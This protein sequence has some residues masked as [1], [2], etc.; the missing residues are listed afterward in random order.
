MQTTK[1]LSKHFVLNQHLVLTAS[2]L[3]FF[4][5]PIYYIIWTYCLPQAYDNLFLRLSS[6][7]L[8]LAFIVQKYWPKSMQLYAQ[9]LWIFLIVYVAPFVHFFLALKNEFSPVWLACVVVIPFLVSYCIRTINCFII[10]L[11]I[12]ILSAI[13]L[14]WITDGLPLF[15]GQ[16]LEVIPLAVFVVAAAAALSYSNQ[17]LFRKEGQIISMTKSLSG[18]IAH[19]MRN[20]LNNIAITANCLEQHVQHQHYNDIVLS[21]NITTVKEAVYEATQVINLLLNNISKQYIDTN[22]F[23][24]LS[25]AKVIRQAL[26]MYPFIAHQEKKITLEVQQDFNL[27]GKETLINYTL[28][29][30]LKNALYYFPQNPDAEINILITANEKEHSIY[31]RDNT[32]GIS[33]EKIN[34]LFNDFMTSKKNCGTGLGLSFCKRAMQ[35]MQG[36]ISCKSELGKYTEFKLSFPVATFIDAPIP[37]KHVKQKIIQS[38]VDHSKFKGQT[39][40]FIEDN[41]IA[42]KQLAQLLANIDLDV[43]FACNHFEGMKKIQQLNPEVIV[44]DLNMPGLSGL[45]LL[46]TIK[47]A[48]LSSSVVISLSGNVP[49]VQM[50]QLLDDVIVKPIQDGILLFKLQ[51]YLS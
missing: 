11:S 46:H 45:E 31:F 14:Y 7:C 37:K 15:V 24:M 12:G 8:G 32:V 16:H 41:I 49:C 13:F 19:E 30:L 50:Q 48:A 17:L 27:L 18:S 25:I 44:T 29:N 3:T 33:K 9:Y 21:E 40:L 26:T 51:Q 28:F 47:Q 10:T 39:I 22:D 1:F 36:E 2:Y 5:S 6:S 42:S 35:A 43:H 34:L 20:P 23:K 38:K 4:C